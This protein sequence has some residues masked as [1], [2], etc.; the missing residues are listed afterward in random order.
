MITIQN[1]IDGDYDLQKI[2][3]NEYDHIWHVLRLVID[4]EE[5]SKTRSMEKFRSLQKRMMDLVDVKFSKIKLTCSVCG[6]E[7]SWNTPCIDD[8]GNIYCNTCADSDRS[9]KM[10]RGVGQ[11]ST[12][13]GG[14]QSDRNLKF[15]H[16][17]NILSFYPNSHGFW[18]KPPYG[19]RH[20]MITE[21]MYAISAW[22]SDG[23]AFPLSPSEKME[24][25]QNPM[26]VFNLMKRINDGGYFRCTSCGGGFPIDMIGGKP[27]FAGKVCIGCNVKH[28]K[29]LKE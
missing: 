19:G 8:T 6:K 26:S 16:N 22:T 1:I 7:A 23:S 20:I 17:G 10:L 14:L 18:S 5:R 12:W 4:E 15:Q 21:P 2:R 11:H 25:I 3:E 9:D 28:E 27:L 24:A 13:K 29:H